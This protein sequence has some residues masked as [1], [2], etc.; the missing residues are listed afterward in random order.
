MNGFINNLLSAVAG[1][2]PAAVYVL[3]AL[4]MVIETSVFVALVIPGDLAVLAAGTTATDPARFVCLVAAATG[5]SLAGESLGY[6]IGR[7]F[8]ARIRDSRLG[9]RLGQDRWHKAESY[10]NRR[11]GLPVAASRFVG[12]AH[13]LVPVLAGTVRMPYRRY[14]AWTSAGSLTWSLAYVGVGAAAGASYRE[15]G[16]RLSLAVYAAVAVVLVGALIVLIIRKRRRRPTT[17]APN[18]NRPPAGVPPMG[19]W[20]VPALLLLQAGWTGSTL[21]RP[22]LFM[23]SRSRFMPGSGVS[24][25]ELSDSEPRARS[26]EGPPGVK[27]RRGRA[28]LAGRESHHEYKAGQPGPSAGVVR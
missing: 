20:N 16:H 25:S 1:L 18:S 14:I 15:H 7:R 4:F 10:L 23:P 26:K 28:A 5:G 19:A 9:R 17:L 22:E 2:D 27:H 13:A 21:W 11:G 24:A 12:V 3:T 6:L 8:G